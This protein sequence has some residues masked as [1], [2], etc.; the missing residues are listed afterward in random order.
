MLPAKWIAVC[1]AACVWLVVAQGSAWGQQPPVLA[2]S[3]IVARNAAARGGTEAWQQLRTMVWTGYVQSAAQPN[4]KLSFLL[5]QERP[6]KTRFEVL[7]EGQKS[8]RVFN[9]TDGWKVRVSS[10]G[11]PEMQAFSA[12]ERRFAQGTQVIDGPLMDAAA[13]GRPLTLLGYD[14]VEDHAAYVLE[15][16]DEEGEVQRI[17]V[18][19]QSFLELRLDRS[20]RSSAG[21]SSMSTVLYRDYRAFEGLQIPV[22][23]ESGAANDAT[24]NRMVIERVALNPPL[25]AETFA[26]PA[27]PASRHAGAT[28]VDLRGLPPAPGSRQMPRPA[29]SP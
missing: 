12:D 27:L 16:K 21:Q 23:V 4:A 7:A 9:E 20:F 2:V 18:D 25:D 3:E 24:P 14:R 1:R 11:K 13:R 22:L 17:W 19:A 5:E 10:G 6:Q 26:R 28:V 8:V 15:A 29:N